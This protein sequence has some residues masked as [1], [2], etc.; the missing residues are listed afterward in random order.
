[1]KFFQDIG[2]RDEAIGNMLA[3]FPSLL[4]YSLY[5]KI[6]PVVGLF[7]VLV[8]FTIRVDQLGKQNNLVE[9][10]IENQM[11]VI[12]DILDHESRGHREEYRESHS[13]GAGAVGMQYRP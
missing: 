1:M 7:L 13:C 8:P 9:K 3:K 5:K 4:T 11:Y 2:I 10:Y 12:G 6:R